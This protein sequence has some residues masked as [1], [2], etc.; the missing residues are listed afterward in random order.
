MESHNLSKHLENQFEKNQNFFWLN[1]RFEIVAKLIQ[2][3]ECKNVLD[4]G[5][6]SG[7]LRNKLFK[8]IDY[9]FLEPDHKSREELIKKVGK[10]YEY[11]KNS[12]IKFDCI[13]ILDVVEH[14][15]NPKKFIKSYLDQLNPGGKIIIS[16]PAYN[17]LWSNWDVVLG[18]KERFTK[19]S[20]KNILPKRN[21]KLVELTYLF[22][23]LVLP[24]YV[25]K[26]INSKNENFPEINKY[27][28]SFFFYLSKLISKLRKI[29]PFGL[30]VFCIIEKNLNS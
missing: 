12:E 2:K 29:T 1:V 3:W 11:E 9:F 4:V 24:A 17:F 30:S 27:L 5:A 20:L 22:P 21:V 14:V 28:N 16:V 6:G 7:A 15:D 8:N 23:E 10:D 26:L 18:H 19:K 25:R 13:S